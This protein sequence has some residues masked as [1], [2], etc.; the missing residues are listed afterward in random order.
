MKIS[1]L[2]LFP[3]MFKGPF[4]NSI[5]KRAKE[6]N[7]IEIEYI[8]IRDFGLGVH[9][10]VD[11][12]PY[13]GGTGMIMRMDVLC[14]AIQYTKE[15]ALQQYN[16]KTIKQF[17]VLMSASGKKFTQATAK[18]LTTYDHLILICGHYE[19]IDE[20]IKYFIDDEISIA[21]FVVTGGE[22]PSMLIIDSVVRLIPNV[23]KKSATEKESF[24]YSPFGHPLLEYPQYTKPET[25]KT[26]AV[27]AIL[28]SGNHKK[29]EEWRKNEALNKT[30]AVRPDL[31]SLPLL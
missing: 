31:L 3:E 13:G 14:K 10:Q 24:S 1:I 12:T 19:G 20:R 11:D 21:D 22:L 2:T 9:K 8:N 29:I 23:L 18:R 25:F 6:K 16:N 28:L 7:L 30:K 5:I 27:P 17:T 26:L 4:D 15:K